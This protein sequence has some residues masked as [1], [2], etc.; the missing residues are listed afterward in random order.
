MLIETQ[1]NKLTGKLAKQ[2]TIFFIIE[3]AKETM[4]DFLQETV[5]YSNVIFCFN[6]K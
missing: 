2:A 6:T 5:K 1:L 4:L 3:E